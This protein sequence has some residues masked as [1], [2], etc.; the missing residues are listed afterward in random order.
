ME[1]NEINNAVKYLSDLLNKINSSLYTYIN[2]RNDSNKHARIITNLAAPREICLKILEL[3]GI[4]GFDSCIYK[5]NSLRCPQ[6]YKIKDQKII[7]NYYNYNKQLN[8]EQ[9][10]IQNIE[11]CIIIEQNLLSS[12][13]K[14][15]YEFN[16]NW[17]G[18][19]KLNE[20]NIINIVFETLQINQNVK[21]LVNF[22]QIDENKYS[23]R[24]NNVNYYCPNCNSNHN[25]RFQ[26]LY[27]NQFNIILVCSASTSHKILYQVNTI[28]KN[29]TK[30]ERLE[31]KKE[32]IKSIIQNP[33][34]N[35]NL[36]QSDI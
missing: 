22:V 11:N 13:L 8:Y 1:P 36:S 26:T 31:N 19:L 25:R 6:S 33:R 9:Q 32:L 28:D 14:Q 30:Q 34:I 20:N 24:F 17:S 7:K 21:H 16:F 18:E 35:I 27:L 29:K 5:S 23:I 3:I 15:F 12:E 2:F 4:N 10:F